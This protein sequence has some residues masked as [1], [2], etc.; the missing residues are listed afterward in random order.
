[1]RYTQNFLTSSAILDRIINLT[2][3]CKTDHVIEIGPGKGHI[4][5]KFMHKR[6]KRHISVPYQK[7]NFNSVKSGRTP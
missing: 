6:Q 1:M 7:T 5:D 2:S 3:L 4:T